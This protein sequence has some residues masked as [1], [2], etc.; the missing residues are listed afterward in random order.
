MERFVVG[1]EVKAIAGPLLH[2]FHEGHKFRVLEVSEN[3]IYKLDPRAH[4][5]ACVAKPCFAIHEELELIPI[6]IMTTATGFMSGLSLPNMPEL[7]SWVANGVDIAITA[8]TSLPRHA[9]SAATAVV[10]SAGDAVSSVSS[11]IGSCAGAVGDTISSSAEVAGDILSGCGD[12]V[13]DIASGIA[14]SL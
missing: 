6:T 5:E 2:L 7:P 1:S 12:A 4:N 11:A 3:G 9:E 10:S 8:A 14:D 13:G